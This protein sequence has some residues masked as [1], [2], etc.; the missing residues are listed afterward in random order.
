MNDQ[1]AQLI[2]ISHSFGNDKSYVIAGGGNS[3]YK[4]QDRIWIKASGTSMKDVTEDKFAVLDRHLL[5]VLYNK[6]YSTDNL[7]REAEVKADLMKACIEGSTAR[8]SVETS[9]HELIGYSYVMHT[10]PLLVNAITCSNKAGETLGK[11]FGDTCLFVPYTDP[12]YVLFNCVKIMLENWRKSHGSDPKVI[13]L[14]NHGVFVSSDS[15][16]EIIRIYKDLEITI[17]N[18]IKA[19]PDMNAAG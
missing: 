14:Q 8:P 2:E 9:L 6:N 7:K 12:G 1:I 3:S 16:E 19:F 17:R 11:I 15:C 18:H 13:F 4:N 5:K 10:H